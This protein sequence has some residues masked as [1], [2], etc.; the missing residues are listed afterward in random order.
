M[1]GINLANILQNVEQLKSAR[2]SRE[3][4]ALRM[5]QAEKQMGYMDE[6]RA[7]VVS[8]RQNTLAEREAQ[9]QQ[10]K[11]MNA[12][13]DKAASGDQQ[14]MRQFIALNPQE[15]KQMLEAFQKL[16]E[17]QKQQAAENIETIGRM[18][19]YILQSDNPEQA[20][21]RVKQNIS[22]EAAKGMPEQYDRN[23]VTMQLARAREIEQLLTPDPNPDVDVKTFGD[24]DIMFKN[25][26]EVERTSSNTL[27]RAQQSSKEEGEK[28]GIKT[29][30][31]SLMYRQAAELLGGLF[32]QQGNLQNLD[33]N[34]RSKVQ[35]IATEA[36]RIRESGEATTNSDA[37]AK[38]ARKLKIDIQDLSGVKSGSTLR[39][40][41]PATGKF[42]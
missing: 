31:E 1:A 3:I 36:A 22:P 13:R 38:A 23:Y 35:A 27:L 19:A 40:F 37:V 26:Q 9:A 34:T 14:A 25:G 12:L 28:G 29:A 30:D 33:P 39:T 24:Q 20:Y 32:D 16:D 8:E 21:Q 5:Q 15:G 2:Q 10:T 41:N 17:P 4:N 11:Q 6:D 42:E 7:W 18:A